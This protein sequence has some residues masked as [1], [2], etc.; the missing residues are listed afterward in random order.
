MSDTTTPA[1][2]RLTLPLANLKGEDR[3]KNG[4]WAA[5]IPD[6]AAARK[7]IPYG[8]AVPSAPLQPLSAAEIESLGL[9][10]GE[11]RRI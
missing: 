6:K 3:A 9:K 5:A 1:G 8:A 7:A 2:W 10:A 4:S 11:V